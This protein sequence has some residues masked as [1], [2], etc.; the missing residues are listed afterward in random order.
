MNKE[1]QISKPIA[2]FVE[3]IKE[4]DADAFLALFADNAVITDEGNEYQGIAAIREWNDEKNTGAEIILTPVAT[5]DRNG[6]TILTV[7]VDGNFDKTRLPD[8]FLMDLYFTLDENL[9]TTLEYRLAGE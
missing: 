6:K 1:L 8:P 4:H 2:D 3:A 5:T 7:E 9:I